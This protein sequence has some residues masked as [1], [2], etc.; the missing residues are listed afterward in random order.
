MLYKIMFLVTLMI[1]SLI[2]ISS[3]TWMGMWLGLEINLLSIIPLMNNNNIYSSEASMKYFITQAMASTL[4]MFAIISMFLNMKFMDNKMI[5]LNSALM[6]KIG[7]APFHFWFPEIMEG[8]NWLNCL[9]LLTWQ[10]L[11]PMIILMYNLIF[12]VF[13]IIIIILSMLI[14]S[15]MGLN[16]ISLRK[17][18]AFSSINHIGWLM[19]SM[20]YFNSI[21]TIYYIIYS[22]ISITLTSMFMM[23]N[24]FFMKQIFLKIKNNSLFKLL[25]S[26]N[27][28]SL[29]GLPPFIGFMPKW[30]VIQSLVNNKMLMMTISMMMI[31]LITLFYYI[32]I[33]FS[34]MLINKNQM[35]FNFQINLNYKFLIFINL[36]SIFGLILVNLLFNLM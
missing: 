13:L 24:I 8:L 36:I 12:P 3:N 26:M 31:T 20:M 34:M 16:Q 19:A 23:F 11:A 15:I 28:L 30:L 17:I 18:M 1:G 5:I 14:G 2:S 32:R 4:I 35:N 21:W 7:A 22:M 9:L 33:M 6:I 27:L 29:G 25:F 10:K